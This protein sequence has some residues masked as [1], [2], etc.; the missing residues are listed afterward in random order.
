MS[1]EKSP[2]DDFFYSLYGFYPSKAG[3]S[4]ELLTNAALKI[5]NKESK[6]FYDQFIDGT[7]SKQKYQIDGIIDN[8]SIESK[9][10]TINGDKVGRP[11][12]QNQ[13]GGLIDLP[14]AEGIFSSAT[15]YTRN[16]KKYAK[17]T[18]E[19]PNAKRI[20]LYNIRPSSITDEEGR[21]KTVI[22]DFHITSLNYKYAIFNPTFTKEGMNI[23]GNLFPNGKHPIKLD[24]ILNDDSSVF[25]TIEDWTKSL[26]YEYSLNDDIEH[27][28][29]SANFPDKYININE[30]MI[31][32]T[33]INYKIPIQKSSEQIK[34]ERDGN[35]CLYVKN[36][37]GTVDTLLT[38][39]KMKSIN[40]DEKDK[41]II[42]P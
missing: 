23:L 19:N 36:E 13:E 42:F 7:Y 14:F 34:I 6:V 18:E 22:L 12:V 2:I 38:D 16:A 40:F 15:G 35:A 29:G 3:K 39:I 11:E 31:G 8:I 27:L 28:I 32:I 21:V 25:L 5:L 9:D 10:H 4:F 1:Y 30:N 17:G 37:S 33:N 20:E 41:E 26:N 24:A